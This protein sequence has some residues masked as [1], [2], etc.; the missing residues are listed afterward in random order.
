M[1]L[2]NSDSEISQQRPCRLRLVLNSATKGRI[3]PSLA[4]FT[5]LSALTV[6]LHSEYIIVFFCGLINPQKTYFTIAFEK[7][8]FKEN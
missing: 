5:L 7:I 2:F 8:F 3:P 4:I 6:R 1:Y